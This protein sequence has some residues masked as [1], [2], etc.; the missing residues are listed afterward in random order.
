V[1]SFTGQADIFSVVGARVGAQASVPHED[2]AS[3]IALLSLWST[4][5]SAVGGAVAASMWT[6]DMPD[7]IALYLPDVSPQI[8]AKLYGSITAITAYDFDD[9]IRQGIIKAYAKTSGPIAICALCLAAVPLLATFFMP[10]FY[11][12]EQQNAVTGTGLDGQRVDVPKRESEPSEG[13]RKWLQRA[14]D[15]YRKDQ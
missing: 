13:R 3:V 1:I 6:A 2:L 10:D 5:G 7:N 11:L 8:R 9:P 14:R 12:G 4:L 15:A